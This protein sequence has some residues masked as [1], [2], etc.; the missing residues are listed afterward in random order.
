MQPASWHKI[1]NPPTPISYLAK[2]KHQLP[3]PP[4]EKPPKNRQS[5]NE[6]QRSRAFQ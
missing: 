4:P 5:P 6:P 2:L 3:P 1:N